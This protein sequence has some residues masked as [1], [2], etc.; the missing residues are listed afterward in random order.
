MQCLQADA[1]V[2]DRFLPCTEPLLAR[3]TRLPGH[4]R[5][6]TA[7]AMTPVR[8]AGGFHPQAL[9]MRPRG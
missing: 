8:T 5:A 4:I 7:F 1:V 2:L 3:G 6:G 9:P